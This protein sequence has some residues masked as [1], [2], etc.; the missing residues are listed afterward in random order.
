MSVKD[1]ED[2]FP[3]LPIEGYSISSA[4]T[5]DYNCFAFAA[6]DRDDWWSPLQISGYYWPDHIPRNTTV[7]TFLEL[8]GYEGG[9]V[10][11]EDGKLEAGFEKIAL[12]TNANRH[13]THAAR[14]LNSG[15]WTS[16]LG[17]KEDIEHSTLSSLEDA[18]LSLDDYGK[19]TQFLKRKI[20][21]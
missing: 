3:K 14:Q 5:P 17:T 1:I 15:K 2:E 10:P 6:Y 19:V 12:Y 8:Y 18:G 9:F 11:C 16:K 4:D 21:G 20:Q 13:V 7:P